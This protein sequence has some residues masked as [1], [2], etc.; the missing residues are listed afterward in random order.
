MQGTVK[1]LDGPGSE[2]WQG[3]N[4][5]QFPKTFKPDL[6]VQPASI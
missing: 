6:G 2:F 4:V 5:D 1:G 3:K